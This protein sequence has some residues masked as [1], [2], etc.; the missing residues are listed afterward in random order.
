MET[1][2]DFRYAFGRTRPVRQF[3]GPECGSSNR[4][5]SAR[6]SSRVQNS[7]QRTSHQ[8]CAASRSRRLGRSSS[9]A[10]THPRCSIPR[11]LPRTAPLQHLPQRVDATHNAN[12]D[13]T[14]APHVFSL[15]P[16]PTPGRCPLP[17]R[18]PRMRILRADGLDV[19]C[20][21][22]DRLSGSDRSDA[23]HGVSS[24]GR[25]GCCSC[26]GSQ[27]RSRTMTS[28]TRCATRWRNPEP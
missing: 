17:S 10:S 12:G 18:L 6:R 16:D 26:M 5:Y 20:L 2:R 19:V 24:P 13:A 14:A 9:G 11:C 28:P 25:P 15:A 4:C 23:A 7:R 3:W 27:A 8:T 21:L 1:G 22:M